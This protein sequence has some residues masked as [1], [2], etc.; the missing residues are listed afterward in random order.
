MFKTNNLLLFFSLFGI[1]FLSLYGSSFV[2]SQTIYG[3]SNWQQTASYPANVVPLSCVA[4]SSYVYCVGNTVYYAPLSPSGIGS[5]TQTTSFPANFSI[6]YGSNINCVTNSSYIYCLSSVIN[7]SASTILKVSSISSTSNPPVPIIKTDTTAYYASL[8][9]SGISSWIQTTS[10]PNNSFS[11]N[12]VVESKNIFC[13]NSQDI[14]EVMGTSYYAPINS[15]GI[16]QWQKTISYPSPARESSCAG[17]PGFIYCIGG[18][19]GFPINNTYYAPINSSGIG[20]WIQSAD[21]PLDI[22]GNSCV[23]ISGITYCIG[24]TEFT[25]NFGSGTT[26]TPQIKFGPTNSVYF[27]SSSS[28]GI[29]G[30]YN[31]THNYPLNITTPQCVTN[32]SYIYCIGGTEISSSGNFLS[33]NKSYY[34]PT[35]TNFPSTTTST[36]TTSTITIYTITSS[37]TYS[38]VTTTTAYPST[39][40]PTIAST[41]VPVYINGTTSIPV[42]IAGTSSSIPVYIAGTTSIPVYLNGTTSIPVYIAGTSTIFPKNNLNNSTT[43]TISTGHNK[44]NYLWLIIIVVII[45]AGLLLW[46]LIKK[47]RSKGKK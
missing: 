42:Y 10:Y 11:T 39:L 26:T 35:S 19:N 17:L 1:L 14:N 40:L 9:T 36:T 20:Q 13:T 4:Y 18:S 25:I 12:C 27:S 45:I 21:Y 28:S 5:W 16:G 23:I 7:I 29:L 44:G 30:W 33:I 37:P 46:L 6:P 31:T 24:G 47:L 2:H 43:N 41:I 15:S 8:S 22:F 38:T 34:A 3:I 32:S